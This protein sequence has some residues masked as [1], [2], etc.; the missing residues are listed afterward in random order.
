ML[1]SFLIALP[2][3]MAGATLASAQQSGACGQP[4]ALNAGQITLDAAPDRVIG[5]FLS[6]SRGEPAYL[7]L[8]LGQRLDLVMRT[9]SGSVDPTLILFDSTGRVIAAND[10]HGEGKNA[11]IVAGLDAGTY[12]LQVAKFGSLDKPDAMIPVAI[13]AAPEADACTAQAG[14]AVP[15]GAEP[16]THS[17]RISGAYR[18]NLDIDAG[19]AITVAANSAVFDTMLRLQDRLGAVV[20]ENDDSGEGTNSLVT[21]P[22]AP[23][24]RRLCVEL[25]SLASPGTGEFTLSVSPTLP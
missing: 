5:E 9:D 21:L 13:S 7:E 1:K 11:R 23:E 25:T 6:L 19:T 3:V 24:A 10:D 12:C 8:T 22:A 15:I 20:A 17:G 4:V 2:L 18:L 14:Q 16:Y